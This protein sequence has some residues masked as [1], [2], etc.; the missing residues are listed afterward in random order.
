[1]FFAEPARAFANLRTALKPSGRLAFACWRFQGLT[2]SKCA[3][4]AKHTREDLDALIALA[5]DYKPGPAPGALPLTYFDELTDQPTPKPWVIKFVLARGELSSWIAPPGAGKSSLFAEIAIHAAA[6]MA[7]RGYRVKQRTGVVIFAFERADLTKRRLIAH[8]RRDGLRNLPI[9]VYGKLINMLDPACAD[10]IL[11]TI[12]EAEQH[13]GCEVG[14]IIFDTYAKGIAAG[15]GD[16]DKARD[17]NKVHANLRRLFELGGNFHIAGV[18]HTGKDESRG[19]RGSNA[20]LA[21]VDLQV[22]I[23]GDDI[24]TA[25][26]TKA[27]DQ[28]E[29]LLTRF[30]LEAFDF[31]LDEDGD[32]FQVSIV[33]AAVIP[34]AAQGSKRQKTTDRQTLALR[35]LADVVLRMGQDPPA[36]YQLPQ[37]IKVVTLKDWEEELYRENVLDRDDLK[38]AKSRF[39]E[40]RDGLAARC[41][42]GMRDIWVWSA[43]RPI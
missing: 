22:Q 35:A 7:W 15:D 43:A 18:G 40:L 39:K 12:R 24:R 41:L 31:E 1:M 30:K 25:T 9:A 8:R 28:P 14:L 26:V 16:E 38:H 11:A 23:S 19:E 5:P 3:L 20:R 42:I 32:P 37:G 36:T 34:A 6:G 10:I 21:D 17:Q 4:D 13:M 33:S 29:G 2:V 27:N